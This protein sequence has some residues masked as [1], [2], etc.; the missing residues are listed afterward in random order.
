M[1][2]WWTRPLICATCSRVSATTSSPRDG[3]C[4]ERH[5]P[6]DLAGVHDHEPAAHQLVEHL[7]S[8]LT[9]AHPQRQVGVVRIGEP[10]DTLELDHAA[11]CVAGREVEHSPASD[12]GELVAVAD[13]RHASAGGVGELEERPG[14]VL[15][16]HP[17]LVDDQDGTAVQPW[18][19][20][21]RCHPSPATVLVPAVAVLVQ[22][23][24]HRV[25]CRA[26]LTGRDLGGLPGRRDDQHPPAARLDL[27]SLSRRAAAS[28]PSRRRP[29]PR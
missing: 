14:G 28:C 6:L 10:T 5:G 4:S 9:T 7:T 3:T 20:G 8:S 12:G 27:R 15:V 23:P 21:R 13:Q 2:T 19:I 29:R 11:G 16:E 18:R 22:Q 1:R 25:R 24:R 26:D 17:G